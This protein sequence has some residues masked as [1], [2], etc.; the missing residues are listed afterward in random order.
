MTER[1]SAFFAT[2]KD[3]PVQVRYHTEK[4]PGRPGITVRGTATGIIRPELREMASIYHHFGCPFMSTG[5]VYGSVP[6]KSDARVEKLGIE[7]YMY[8]HVPVRKNFT[9]EWRE[10]WEMCTFERIVHSVA[11]LQAYETDKTIF[12]RGIENSGTGYMIRGLRIKRKDLETMNIRKEDLQHILGIMAG[13]AIAY[14][15]SQATL[16]GPQYVWMIEI[17]EPSLYGAL[18]A[19][20]DADAENVLFDKSSGRMTYDV[21]AGTRQIFGSGPLLVNAKSE[22]SLFGASVTSIIWKKA[23]KMWNLEEEM[24]P[25]IFSR[26]KLMEYWTSHTIDTA[27]HDDDMVLIGQDYG[28][29]EP[30]KAGADTLSSGAFLKI[31]NRIIPHLASGDWFTTLSYVPI[32][33]LFAKAFRKAKIPF[34]AVP[35]GD[36][37]NCR[38]P[39]KYY[40]SA[41]ALFKPYD[42]FKSIKSN[43]SKILGML[44]IRTEIKWHLLQTPRLMKTVT[45]ASTIDGFWDSLNDL[46]LKSE[47][48]IDFYIPAEVEEA[49][50]AALPTMLEL[51]YMSGTQTE[52]RNKVAYA[53]RRASTLEFRETMSWM[54][55][56]EESPAA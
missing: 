23:I 36:D 3:E 48:I 18:G 6:T 7:G 35:L 13:T 31:R 53:L 19:R 40:E 39:K 34:D 14:A 10:F 38:V 47:G 12:S 52:L 16:P 54:E 50:Q 44:T 25:P 56:M 55:Y 28:M 46:N 43:I 2:T 11:M 27:T 1:P 24:F 8:K 41:I 42:K 51:G 37:F 17:N 32:H 15:V 4:K 20:S 29:V 21:T 22:K 30:L 5:F 45:S 33:Y 26:D 9:D 49:V